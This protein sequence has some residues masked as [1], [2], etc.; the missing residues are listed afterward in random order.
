MPPQPGPKVFHLPRLL[1]VE[2]SHFSLYSAKPSIEVS[3]NSGVFCLAGANGL[4]KS[5][6]LAAINYGLTG[7]VP[8]PSRKFESVPEY[9]AYNLDF[10]DQFFDGRVIE[11]DRERAS[12]SLDL[13]AGDKKFQ[14]SRGVFEKQQLRTLAISDVNSKRIHLDGA[15]LSAEARHEQFGAALAESI[16]LRSFDQF[17][18][19]QHFVF[20]FDERRHLLFWD[21]RVLEQALYLSFGVDP[22]DAQKAD[23]LR[24]EFDKAD[25]LVRNYQWQATELRKKVQE[26]ESIANQNANT[27]DVQETMAQYKQLLLARDTTEKAVR[28]LREQRGDVDVQYAK[29]T[30]NVATCT[31]DYERAFAKYLKDHVNPESHPLIKEMLQTSRCGLCGSNGEE[32]LDG[33]RKELGSDRCPL[34]NS[35]FKRKTHNATELRKLDSALARSKEELKQIIA[36]R[37]RIASETE[38]IEHKLSAATAAIDKFERQNVALLEVETNK[39]PNSLDRTIAGYREQIDSL[40]AKKAT[41]RERRED[42]NKQLQQ[43]RRRLV[44]QYGEAEERFV[45]VFR[46]LAHRFL[47]IDLDVELETKSAAVFLTLTVRDTPR[48]RIFQLSESQRFFVDIALRMAL[49]KFTSLPNGTA[50][51][52]IDTP[53]G[54]LDIAYESRVGDMFAKFALDGFNIIMTA[55]I[56]TSQLLLTLARR[57]GKAHMQLCRMTTWTDLSEVQ[58]AE[59]HLFAKAYRQ[60][61]N[62]MSSGRKGS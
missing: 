28:R 52:L 60:I 2:L 9:Y 61:V 30:A 15:R 49:L 13:I 35:N 47:G 50:C 56:N 40:L 62:E 21:Q 32:I 10:S 45:P 42:R 14:I 1:R 34:C 51:L 18:F 55:N 23:S 6:F 48:R 7:I 27:S 54:S 44:S 22:E 46:E 5:T 43:L 58:L 3:F 11:K 41:Q 53:E 24:R 16:G 59:E 8:D 37:E 38:S 31:A 17:V 57:C 20:T 26:L 4:G 12:V 33:I 36:K 19:L 25:S 39:N 29:T